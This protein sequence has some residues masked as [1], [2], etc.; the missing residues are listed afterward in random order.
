[1][2]IAGNLPQ[3]AYRRSSVTPVMPTA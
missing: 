2:E 1:M 3:P